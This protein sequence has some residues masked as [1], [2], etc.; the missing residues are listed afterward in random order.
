MSSS[1]I[2]R[3]VTEDGAKYNKLKRPDDFLSFSSAAP[4]PDEAIKSDIK[5]ESTKRSLE[6]ADISDHEVKEEAIKRPRIQRPPIN[7]DT[8]MHSMFPG[9][10][11][12]EAELSDDSTT[13]E[14]LAY[15][16]GVR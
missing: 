13:N 10:L 14:A 4:P 16:R 1:G 8:G 11:D 3:A 7:M 6:E 2:N 9:M 5:T 15:L 12:A